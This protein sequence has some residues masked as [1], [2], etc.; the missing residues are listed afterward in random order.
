MSACNAYAR[1]HHQQSDCYRARSNARRLLLFALP[2]P[3][4]AT[5]TS[6]APTCQSTTHMTT[7][8]KAKLYMIHDAQ[9]TPTVK[10]PCPM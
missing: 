3:R 7:C 9:V 10:L 5:A 1:Q 6:H 8:R 4:A 2:S